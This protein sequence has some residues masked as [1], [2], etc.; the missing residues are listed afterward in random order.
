MEI[1]MTWGHIV[2]ALSSYL[3]FKYARSCSLKVYN[4][5]DSPFNPFVPYKSPEICLQWERGYRY[6]KKKMQLRHRRQLARRLTDQVKE[7]SDQ[8]QEVLEKE[9]QGQG[10]HPN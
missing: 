9:R 7:L 2:V 10:Y 8:V 6:G 1:H 3:L 4:A 5:C